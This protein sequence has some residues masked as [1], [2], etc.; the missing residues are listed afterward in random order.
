MIPTVSFDSKYYPYE[1]V[2]TGY[3]TMRGAEEIP[4]KI[5]K[6][7][8][9]LP[10]KEGYEPVDDND[11]PRVRFIKYLFHDGENPL[12]KRLPTAEEKLALLFDPTQPVINSKELE[13]K[14]PKGYRLFAQTKIGQSQLEAKTEIKCYIGKVS[15]VNP[16][17]EN[18]S[19]CFDIW[20][21][22]NFETNTKTNYYSRVYDIEQAIIESLH[23]VNIAGVGVIDFSRIYNGE[24][25]SRAIYDEYT[26]VGRSLILN[27]T[28]ME[29]TNPTNTY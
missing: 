8:L 3:N 5:I 14:H 6:Y 29:S 9:D 7:L 19:L 10:D 4:L 2:Q 24:C 11:R 15:P 18:I 21:N 12:A 13:K 25:G 1:K 20:T 17:T 27:I 16:Y 26:N 22:V 23:G 28:W